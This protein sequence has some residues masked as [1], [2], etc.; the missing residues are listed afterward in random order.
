MIRLLFERGEPLYSRE[1]RRTAHTDEI[2]AA[3]FA[4]YDSE[5]TEEAMEGMLF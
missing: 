1:F 3:V 2:D 4:S 5:W